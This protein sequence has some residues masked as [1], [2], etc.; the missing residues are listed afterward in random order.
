MVDPLDASTTVDCA[1]APVSGEKEHKLRS[2]VWEYFDLIKYKNG[3]KKG[4]CKACKVGYK[5]D[6]QKGGTSSMKRHKC[7]ERHSQDIGQMILSAKNGQLSSRVRKIDQMKFQDLISELLIARNVPL[8]LVEWKEFRDICAYLNEDA[9]PISRNTGKADIIKKHN[10]QK[11]SRLV[12]KKIL[13]NKGKYFHV[14]CCDHILALI[15]KDGLVKIDPVVLK[16]RKSV[17]S[18]K[19]SQVRKQKFLDIVD[20]LGMSAVRRGIRQD[21]KTRWHSTYLMLDSCLVYRSVFAHLKEVDS[22]Y[23]DFPTDEEW[24]QIEVVTKFL[25]TFYD[26]T[27]LFSGSKYPTSNLYFEGVCQVQVLLKNESTNEIEFIRDM[28]K[29]MQEKFN[30]YWEN[31]S[32][33]LA[34]TLVLDPRLKLKY[35][36]FAYSKL[37]PDVRQLESKVADVREDMKKLYNEYYTLLRASGSGTQNF[38][39]QTG[40]NSAHQGSE[41]IHVILKLTYV[42]TC[43]LEYAAA[44]ES[45]GDLQS[46]LSEL[47]QY[48]SEKYGFVNQPL[49]ILMYW[50]AQEQ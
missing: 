10:A 31:L 43:G 3:S 21:V 27:T 35:L 23:K 39:I 13:F 33:I 34:M 14:R 16:L 47:D 50:K 28:V 17:K 44:Q 26:L 38:G 4:V 42:S 12:A 19:K 9:K 5:Y 1:P 41:W 24:D 48:L 32:P 37:Y 25:K 20:T 22:D 18:L 36:N 46:D 45:G 15:V 29:E 40:A 7:R 49:D 8:A 30:S 6:N 11:E 2:D